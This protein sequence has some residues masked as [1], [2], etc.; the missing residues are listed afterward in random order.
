M[1]I[2]FCFLQAFGDVCVD[3][4]SAVE[5]IIANQYGSA[6]ADYYIHCPVDGA[7]KESGPLNTLVRQARLNIDKSESLVSEFATIAEMNFSPKDVSFIII[8][9]KQLNLYL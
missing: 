1:L 5:R 9:T 7:I 8:I 4:A 6:V 2:T 3:P